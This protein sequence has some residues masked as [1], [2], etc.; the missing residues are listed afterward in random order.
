MANTLKEVVG[1]MLSSVA[2]AR[3]ISDAETSRIAQS[4]QN[5]TLMRYFP[6]PRIEIKEVSFELK[7]A[8]LEVT[9]GETMVET[10]TSILQDF[11]PETLTQI[12]VA[13]HI[14]NYLLQQNSENVL[15]L[16]P[17]Q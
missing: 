4:Y 9:E 15:Q 17:T 12:R 10:S 16:I 13:A 14:Q 1:A 7:I 11:R 2:N 5:D 6:I 3:M 8:V